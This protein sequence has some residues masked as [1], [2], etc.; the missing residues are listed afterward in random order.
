MQYVEEIVESGRTPEEVCADRPDLLEEVRRQLRRFRSVEAQIDD[1]FP[2]S[3]G[4]ISHMHQWRLRDAQAELPSITGYEVHCLLGHGGM[5]VVYKAKHLKL[6]RPVAVKMLLSGIYASRIERDRFLREAEA[7]ARLSHPNVVQV[8]DMGE[9]DGRPYFTMEL[10]EGGTLCSKLKGDPWPVDRAVALMSR[11]AWA[12]QAAH[13]SGIV[14]RDLKPG[15][16][17]IS[18]DGTPKISDFGLARR[19]DDD[20][21]VT[22]TG[23]RIGTPCYMAPEQ[24]LGQTKLIGPAADIYSLGAILY[25]LLTGRPPFRGESAVE[26]ERQ[27][28]SQEPVPPMR[29][30]SKVPR[31]L[32][33]I[34]LKCLLKDPARRYP[35][36]TELAMDIERFLR[37]QPI[38]AR[39]TGRIERCH[40]WMRRHPT[41]TVAAAASVLVVGLVVVGWVHS[42]LQQAQVANALMHS[43]LDRAQ[44]A[45]AIDGDL[46]AVSRLQNE[47]RWSEAIAV[48]GSAKTILGSGA[49]SELR[50]R[51]AVAAK[52]LDLAIALDNIRLSRVTSGSLVTYKDLANQQYESEFAQAGLGRYGDRPEDVARRVQESPIQ[53]EQLAALD[54]WVFCATD[55]GKRDWVLRVTELARPDPLG[56]SNRILDPA[57]WKNRQALTELSETVPL[58]SVPLPLLLGLGELLRENG[59]DP[60]PYLTR[61]QREHPDD[62]WTNLALGNALLLPPNGAVASPAEAREYY[63]VAV[64]RRPD[65]PVGYCAVGDT[66]RLEYK[67]D[68]A[69]IYYDKSI[70]LDAKYP[71]VYSN[72]GLAYEGEEN[73]A[74]AIEYFNKSLALD[75]K[76]AWS[77]LNLGIAYETEGQP[78]KARAAY[79]KAVALEPNNTALVN[80][81][82]SQREGR[83]LEPTADDRGWSVWRHKIATNPPDFADWWGYLE[84]TLFLGK[85]DEYEQARQAELREFGAVTDPLVTERIGRGCLLI[86]GNEEETRQAVELIDCSYNGRNSVAAD[87]RPY[88]VFAKGFADYRQGDLNGA[89]AIMRTTDPK[90][91]APSPKLILAMALQKSG[92]HDLAER[93]LADAVTSFDWRPERA[94]KSDLWMIHIFRRE[95]ENL[96][97]P[98]L[99]AFLNGAYQ[100][101]DNTERLALLGVCESK[102]RYATEAQLLAD[103]FAADPK[104]ADTVRNGL[105][106]RAACAAVSASDNADFS[107]AQRDA[108]RSRAIA[109]MQGDLSAMNALLDHEPTANLGFVAQSLSQWLTDRELAAIHDSAAIEL[110]PPKQA[111]ECTALWNDVDATLNRAQSPPGGAAAQE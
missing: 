11:L 64:A 108:W 47:E 37:N 63:R 7:V 13:E 19:V 67:F 60:S 93:T 65:A 53:K 16:I 1:L 83:P 18:N 51:C 99:T 17:L 62:F 58:Q 104:L 26:T 70:S 107:G 9:C 30:N 84:L 94:T 45:D 89:I 81:V 56:W 111:A 49:D 73:L 95:A 101:H 100:P 38:E 78:D 75:P 44:V 12:V 66:Y 10:V 2:S 85:T 106:F 68:Q 52:N 57:D 90:G 40:K 22:L 92:Q 24:A 5:G 35:T 102:L 69:F 4:A 76:Y 74:K 36:A 91:L 103:A 32:D 88:Y 80:A 8:H 109:W 46:Q 6:N 34:C 77:Y 14:H 28:I 59:V 33:T 15:N 55:V 23:A 43:A 42:A 82:N 54:D 79:R 20:H 86:P 27:L 61:I 50:D 96:I 48:L 29:L 25:E 72:I 41:T 87:L 39:R 110:L 98:N 21:L 105:R 31:D 97:L 71:R 3:D